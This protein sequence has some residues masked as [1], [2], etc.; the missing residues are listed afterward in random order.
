MNFIFSCSQEPTA[1]NKPVEK[2][3]KAK[4]KTQDYYKEALEDDEDFYSNTVVNEGNIKCTEEGC[5]FQCVEEDEFY[6][7]S[8]RSKHRNQKRKTPLIRKR[9]EPLCNICKSAFS[10]SKQ[11]DAHY[12][13]EHAAATYQCFKD[14]CDKT[15]L[16]KFRFN[17]HMKSHN[18]VKCSK[19]NKKFGRKSDLNRHIKQKHSLSDS[20][21]NQKVKSLKSADSSIEEWKVSLEEV[22]GNECPRKIIMFCEEFLVK[23]PM[24]EDVWLLLLQTLG[25]QKVG[26]NRLIPTYNKV[27]IAHG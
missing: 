23:F 11:L 12:R 21:V 4:S 3:G 15:Y 14:G 2:Q 22:K 8:H 24:C 20:E 25:S 10:D 5:D 19:C 13:K 17:E 26:R 6:A 1:S 7:R 27:N 16:Q 9:K 18:K